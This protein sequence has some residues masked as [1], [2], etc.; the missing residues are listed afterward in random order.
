MQEFFPYFQLKDCDRAI[1]A[2]THHIL[3]L[4]DGTNQNPMDKNLNPIKASM[5][6]F[7]MIDLIESMGGG[8]YK[9]RSVSIKEEL[10]RMS[11]DYLN[12]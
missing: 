2:L 6:F 12:S 1:T 5:H 4:S 9:I 7:V 10:T 3:P 11:E 8:I